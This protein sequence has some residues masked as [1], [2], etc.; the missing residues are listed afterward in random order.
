MLKVFI[1][2]FAVVWVAAKCRPTVRL[3]AVLAFYIVQSGTE[4][5]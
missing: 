1:L 2:L 5:E 3:A 4:A